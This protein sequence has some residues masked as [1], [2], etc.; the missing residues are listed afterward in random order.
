[1][2]KYKVCHSISNIVVF[3]STDFCFIVGRQSRR[4][5]LQLRLVLTSTSEWRTLSYQLPMS[6]TWTTRLVSYVRHRCRDT[7]VNRICRTSDQTMLFLPMHFLYAHNICLFIS[8][9]FLILFCR[10]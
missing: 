8:R 5:E 4:M 1:V 9:V 3:L 10:Y 6:R 7:S 2:H